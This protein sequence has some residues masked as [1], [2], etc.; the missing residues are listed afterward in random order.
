MRAK[1]NAED[2]T[3]SLVLVPCGSKGYSYGSSGAEEIFFYQDQHC[4][5]VEFNDYETV[6][7]D[8]SGCLVYLKNNKIIS[9]F[10]V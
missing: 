3:K 1:N 9:S 6:I 8:S 2:L 4:V 7:L 10:S 5:C